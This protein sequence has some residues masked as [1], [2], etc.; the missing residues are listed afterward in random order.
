MDPG[1]HRFENSGVKT[2]QEHGQASKGEGEGD[3]EQR[4]QRFNGPGNM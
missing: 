4:W 3:M 1:G 2:K